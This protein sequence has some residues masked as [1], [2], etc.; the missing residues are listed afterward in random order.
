MWFA[1]GHGPAQ[2]GLFLGLLTVFSALSIRG[3][4]QGNLFNQFLR[5]RI[6]D[7]APV[8]AIAIGLSVGW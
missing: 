2:V 5:N 8:I 1:V 7:F 4:R 6:A 3:F